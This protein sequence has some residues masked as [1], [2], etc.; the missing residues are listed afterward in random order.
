MT[1]PFAKHRFGGA[2]ARALLTAYKLPDFSANGAGQPMVPKTPISP[3]TGALGEGIP[4]IPSGNAI[5][6]KGRGGR[7][8]KYARGGRG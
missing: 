4:G 5:S 8:D 2:K 7:V 1:H 6:G 3:P